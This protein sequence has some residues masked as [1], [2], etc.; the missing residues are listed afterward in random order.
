MSATIR[1]LAKHCGLSVSA[2][3]KALNGYTD[4][5][6]ETRKA[7]EEA[8]RALDYHPNAHARALKAGCSYNIGVLFA[9][10]SQSGLTHPFFSEVL[11]NFKRE[12]EAAGYDITFISHR[13][14]SGRVTYLDHCRYRHVD[15]VCIACV[16]FD[17]DEVQ[18]LIESDLPVVTIDRIFSG[19]DSVC[20]DNAD[21]IRR[22]VEYVYRKGHRRVA[23]IHGPRSA[24]TDERVNS[25]RDTAARLGLTVPK[26][27][28]PQCEYI[29]PISAYKAAVKLLRLQERPTCVLVSD[30]Y[31][32]IGVIKAIY[33]AGLSMPGD[34]SIAGY[35][36]IN[37][38][39]QFSPKLTTIRQD[40]A[41]L[42]RESARQLI[43]LIEKTAENTPR[44][45]VVHS[46]MITGQTVAD[47][48]A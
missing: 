5:S 37:Q 19:R 1:D 36:G 29:N 21:G 2:V 46:E 42:G 16:D 13:M 23:Y 11:E 20:S 34:I 4:I 6:E 8:A 9:D 38:M 48:K 32:A 18:R 31:S 45:L 30:D 10:D 40:T 35:D 26:G 17:S 28:M 33:E 7:V 15:G 3:S 41:A 44:R 12:A 24:V 14:G 47:I 25:F 27:Y 43:S 22:L 39:Q